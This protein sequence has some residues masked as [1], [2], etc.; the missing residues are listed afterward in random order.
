MPAL[1][2]VL[3]NDVPQP[4]STLNP[5]PV[6]ARS[7]TSR[8]TSTRPADTAAYSAGD[9]I[10][11]ATDATAAM[12]FTNIGPAGG[13]IAITDSDLRIDVAAI[14]AGMTSFKLHVYNAA[15]V[16]VLADNAAWDLPES[17]R[18][19]YLG[20]IDLGS[21]ADLGSTLFVQSAGTATK[22]V[23]MGATSSLWGYLVTAGGYTPSNAAVK[24]VRLQS[25][26]A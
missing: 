7:Y 4:V 25:K 3:Q 20:Y 6:F 15:P 26:E 16:G 12:E 14:P 8:V 22:Q 2:S 11:T 13:C 24:A 9:V 19:S 10:G 18:S 1:I 5:V 21:P 23:Q 17:D